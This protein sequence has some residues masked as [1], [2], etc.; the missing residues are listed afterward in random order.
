MKRF[1]LNTA[2]IA[3]F[4][5]TIFPVY[6]MFLTAFK[7]TRDIQ[8]ETPTFWPADPTLDHFATAIGAPG[9][10]TYWRNSLLVTVAAVLIALVVALLAAFAVTRMRW[11]GAGPFVVAVFAAQ[12][13]PWEALLVPVFIIARD[14]DLLDSLAMLTGVYFMITLPFTI[15][16]LRGFLAAIPLELEEAAQVD[17]CSRP[18]AFRRVVFPL[19]APGLMATSLFGFIT[20]WNEFAFVNVLIIKDQDK[21]TLPAWLSS[22]RDVFGTD[23]GATMAAASLFALPALLLFLF[24]QRRVGT[25]MTAGAVKG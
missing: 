13:A 19:L 10:W 3:V 4:V 24:L 25:G 16:T 8:S 15:V 17:G 23:W 7:P 12:M 1:L 20:A 2:A 11:R 6:W 14:T 5:V 9:F 22:F 21:R 18:V